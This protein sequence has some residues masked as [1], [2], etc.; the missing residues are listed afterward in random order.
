M[1]SLLLNILLVCCCF[2]VLQSQDAIRQRVILIGDAGEVNEYQKA[3]MQ[4][5]AKRAMPGKTIALFLGDNIYRSGMALDGKEVMQTADILRN[6]YQPLRGAGI[7]VYFI[8]GN[9]DWDHSGVKGYEKIMRVNEFVREQQDS[10]L[11]MIPTDACP[12]P[13]ELALTDDLVVVAIDSEWWLFPFS[14]HSE[15][16]DCECKTPADILGKLED[17]IQRNKN[18]T[19]I[20]ASHHPF[21]TYGSHGGYYNLRQHVFPF[22][23]LNES[24]YI[25]LPVVGSLY[26]L[27]RKAFPPAEDVKNIL[28]QDMKNG[29]ED[30]LKNHPNI[31]HA[32]GH[33][34]ALQLRQGAV[35]EVVSGAGCKNT[36]VKNGDGTLYAESN[37]G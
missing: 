5:A 10:L 9:H 14:K 8:P 1:K 17:I 28:Y 7:P 4:D 23:D 12:G 21:K 11:Q 24:L 33:E 18:K 37:P 6:Q 36:P 19:I 26:P 31:I 35:L 30:I 29:M 25:P 34:H 3:L 22:T 16:S 32:A 20:F 15:T 2:Q 13:Y 27:L